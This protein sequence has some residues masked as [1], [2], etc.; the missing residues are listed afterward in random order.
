MSDPR[1]PEPAP[2]APPGREEVTAQWRALV[3]GHATRDAVHAWAA[4]WVED[5]A[6][7][8]VPPLILGALQHLHGFDLR[9][10]PRRPG[11]VRHGTA[12][13]GEGEWIHSADDIA[14]ALARWEARCERDDAERAP[15]PQAGGEGEGEG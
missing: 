4:R 15:R 6:D 10:D 13:D 12:G 7:P 5:E 14:A 9:R 2:P 11:V 8:R 3:A 1:A